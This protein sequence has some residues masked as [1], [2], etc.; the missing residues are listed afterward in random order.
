MKY[1]LVVF[2]LGESPVQIGPFNNVF[3]CEKAGEQIKLTT[4]ATQRV[5][6][7]CVNLDARPH[8]WNG[9]PLK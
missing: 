2:L 6:A 7:V 1:L 5:R 3:A 9:K 8:H 4:L